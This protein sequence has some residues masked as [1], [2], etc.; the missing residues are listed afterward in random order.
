MILQ[1]LQELYG[2]LCDDPA[3]EIPPTRY[4]LQKISFK[5]VLRPDGSLVDIQDTRRN[6]R[7]RQIRVLGD[8]KSSG[9]SLNPCFLWDNT[10]YMLG[11]RISDPK[12]ERTR[13][14]FNAFRT[15]HVKLEKEIGSPVFSAVCRFL[16]SWSPDRAKEH[17]ILN[18]I[19]T[20]FGVFQISG[21]PAFVHQD[22]K[23]DDWWRNQAS[24][25]DQTTP[26][27]QCL[28]T[29]KWGPIAR[30]HPMIKGVSGG[31]AL[32]ALVGFNDAAYESYGKEQAFNSPVTEEAAFDYA[33][34]LNALLD[35]PM[36]PKHRITIGDAT[37]VFWTDRPSLVEDIFAIFSQFSDEPRSP[38]SIQDE[39]LRQK[40]DVFLRTLR[41]GIEKCG[42]LALELDQ[43]RFYLLAL[44]PNAARISVRFFYR[45]SIREMLNNLRKHYHDM[46]IERRFGEGAKRP[47]PEFPPL[48]MLLRE[49][50]RES[51]DIPPLLSGPMFRSVLTGVQYPDGLYNA[52]IR[53]IRIRR[54]HDDR[55]ISYIQ[56]CIIKG[57]LVRNQ[58]REVSMSLDVGRKDPAYR[59]GRLF[60]TLEKTQADALGSIGATIRDRF[61]SSASATPRSVFPR[62]LRT[63]QHH[64][65][66]LEGGRKIN[67]EKLLQEIVEPLGDFPAHLNLADQ[68]MFALGYYHQMQ[69]FYRPKSEEAFT[70]SKEE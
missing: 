43:S 38:D 14:S 18:E 11:F 55:E 10:G 46:G 7:P 54:I 41:T 1:S 29:G 22:P 25:I 33:T 61:Y 39:A 9:S 62:L 20:G 4:S 16:E 48:W 58:K 56:A 47:E 21:E 24:S 3:Y 17:P 59:I 32:A 2:R 30:L 35:G 13:A 68:G 19:S 65:A 45:G 50:A 42:D 40:L 36:R 6:G 52:V 23:I 8:T 12:P 37:V 64:L 66:K 31:K 5:V 63:Y 34:A 51:K 15:R 28:L 44:S 67:R 53:R 70:K 26:V 49:T 60:A 57:W 27:G 69:D